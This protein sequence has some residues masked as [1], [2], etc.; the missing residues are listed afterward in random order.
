M[1]LSAH[2]SEHYYHIWWALLNFVNAQ[3]QIIPK[4]APITAERGLSPSKAAKLRDALW[5]DDG[6]RE[7]FIRENPANLSSTDLA[8][9][10]NW[11]KRLAGDFIIL[12]QRK[13]HTVFLSQLNGEPTRAYGV[14]ALQSSFK[15]MLGPFLP[16]FVKAVLLPFEGR[17]IYDGLLQA[18]SILIGPNMRRDWEDLLRDIE[19]REGV[20]TDLLSPTEITHD[21][22]HTRNMKM[23]KQFRKHLYRQG[24]SP[25]TVEQH[26]SNIERFAHAYLLDA[27][28]LLRDVTPPAIA[29][30][31]AIQ[32][33]SPREHKPLVTSFKRFIRFLYDSGRMNPNAYHDLRHT[34]EGF[35][36][37]STVKASSTW[38]GSRAL[39]RIP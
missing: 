6:L 2:D 1:L 25:K 19:E 26:A 21:T 10:A 8:I 14:L 22:A 3:R 32:G 7:Q 9:V 31:L 13:S 20:I 15:E 23:V 37:K 17:I 30:F 5:A 24:L 4:L 27:P 33:G 38:P 16:T 39:R 34:L 11:Q 28:H 29:S 36:T 12:K 35:T 18:Y